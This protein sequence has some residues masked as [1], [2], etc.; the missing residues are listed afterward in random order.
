MN[1]DGKPDLITLNRLDKTLALRFGS[2]DGTFSQP[3]KFPLSGAPVALATGDFSKDGNPDIAVLEDCGSSQC[4]QPGEVEILIGT[5][6]GNFGSSSTYPAGFSPSAIAVGAL[7][8]NGNLDIVVGNRC[9]SDASCKG[10]GSA[11]VLLGDGTGNFTKVND[12]DL[13]GNPASIALGRL[14]GSGNMDIAVSYTALNTLAVLAGNGDGT[15][16]TPVSYAVGSA[17][18]PVVIA[19]LNGDGKPDV[20]VANAKD[21]TVSVLFGAGD[22]TLQSAASFPVGNSPTALAAVQ[23]VNGSKPLLATANGNITSVFLGTELTTL[24]RPQPASGVTAG[25]TTLT[26][27]PATTTVNS[28]TTLNVTVTGGSGTPTGT[29]T[30]TSN[31]SPATVCSSLVLDG[32]GSASCTTSAL[33]ANVTSLTATY[34]G[35]TTYAVSTG[36]AS[37]TVNALHPTVTVTSAPASPSALN[38]SVTFSASL[39]GVALTP[40][41]PSGTFTFAVNGT[42]IAA[43]TQ[44][45]SSAGVATCAIS[46]LPVGANHSV[47]ATYS[48]D[49]NYVASAPGSASYTITALPGTLSL[50][51]SPAGSASVGTSV[52]FTATLSA[53][54]VAPIAPSGTV[55]FTINGIPNADCPAVKVNASQQATCTTRSLQAP[56]D[57]IAATYSGDPNFTPVSG[58][59]LT[60]IVTK[61][62]P[63]VAVTGSPSPASVNQSVTFTATVPSPAGGASTVFPFGS[64]TFTQGANTLCTPVVLSSANPPTA[65]C[66]YS[67]PTAVAA[68]GATVTAIYSGDSNFTSGNPGTTSEIVNTTSTT[69]TVTSTPNPSSVNQ[70]VA[71]T[72]IVTPAFTG[73]TVPQGAVV[74]TDTSTSTTL[75]TVPVASNGAAV[76]NYRFASAGSHSI[77]PSFTTTNSNFSSSVS[78]TL[79]QTVAAGS[80]AVGVTSSLNP[81]T[82]NQTVTFAATVSAV[83]PGAAV[84]QGSITYKDGLAGTTLCS[85]T[86]AS[87][88]SVPTC[89]VPLFSAGAHTITAAFTTSNANFNSG[90]SNGLN[91]VVGRTATTTTVVSAPSTSSVNQPVTFTATVTPALSGSTSPTGSVTFSYTLGTQTGFLC[92]SAIPASTVGSVT[93][94]VCTAPLPSKGTYTISAAY[95]GDHNFQGGSPA[96]LTQAVDALATTISV[97]AQPSSSVVNQP[98]SFTAVIT[99]AFSG[100]SEPTGTV[101]F[102]DTLT[103]TQLCSITV[104]A[105][106][107]APC[108]A[109]LPRAATHTISATYSSGDANFIGSTSA[110]ISHPVLK[111]PTSL[112]LTSSLPTSVVTQPVTFTAVVTPTPTGAAV[113]TGTIAFSSADGTL[114][115]SCSAVPVTANSN[116][117]AA[118]GCTVQFPLTAS[119][120]ISVTATYSGDSNF[121]GVSGTAAPAQTVQNFAIALSLQTKSGAATSGPVL[122]PQ[123]YSTLGASTAADPFN[124][125]QTTVV[126]TSLSGFADSVN[127]T[128]T[129]TKTSTMT[130]VS[131]PSCSPFTAVSPGSG[132]SFAYILSASS[133]AAV[134]QYS[135]TLT[136]TDS[137]NPLLFHSTAPLSVY[138]IGVANSLNLTQGAT[139]TASAVFNTA[140]TASGTPP[141]ALNSLS[142]GTIL[143]VA[144]GSRVASGQVTCSGPSG[145]TAVTGAQTSVPITIKL[146]TSTIAQMQRP[147]PI[148]GVFFGLPLLALV[149][150]FGGNRPTRRSLF[151]CLGFLL[152]I[153]GLLSAVGCGGN[154]TPPAVP[155]SGGISA[156]SYLVQVVAT[157][158]NGAKYYAVVPLVVSS[159]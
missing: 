97:T 120:Q 124:P 53:S 25:T 147:T 36:T 58:T 100:S 62:S 10:V 13:G 96:T 157:D 8:A 72:A 125:V 44:T 129:V 14:S 52:T 141:T 22:G 135:V 116:G 119:G 121:T 17:P 28:P 71:F 122:L 85:V 51:A 70:S 145:G 132:G 99:P 104:S 1:G 47:T 30:I 138:I 90:T 77:E 152:L 76:C 144:D 102:T 60:E 20:A 56:A 150:W 93:S 140:T 82:V 155:R 156:G 159:K 46:S 66:T 81:S 95:S 40:T 18:G 73:T 19:D 114:N 111:A 91:Q 37:V 6:D 24:V 15:F 61:A 65:S 16:Q 112:A 123:G 92:T 54:S 133:V 5:G 89:T 98:V 21:S 136:A 42:T 23:S 41:A 9:G 50:T 63:T 134:G 49:S 108:T 139:G 115:T 38:T 67:F 146:S 7:G 78:A 149:G 106:V 151:A 80:V 43:C 127:L 74:F 154:A 4:A 59:M 29:V 110:V 143:N 32:T 39:T 75:C 11:T 137:K 26:A 57:A 79:P 3:L 34:N 12:V 31:G 142:C 117:T 88:G 64:V 113:P 126:V 55:S 87:N 103:G 83:N 105:G 118:T 94:A 101:T 158:Q 27:T 130:L 148:Y 128:C 48:G 109:S 153:V 84:P 2:G 68:P 35:D 131:D 107:V 69:T 33:Q 86:V 45:V